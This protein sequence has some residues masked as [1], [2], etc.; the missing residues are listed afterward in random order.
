[1]KF[2]IQKN[3]IVTILAKIQGLAGRR[4]SLAIT[5]CIC[6]TVS[7]S[8]LQII[9]TDLE[10]GY[11]GYFPVE[12]EISGT[13]AISA[14]KF[15]EIIREFPDSKIL[16]EESE[17]RRVDIGNQNVQFHIKGM[18]PED[19]PT[20]PT[21]E[22]VDYFTVDASSFKKMIDKT[23]AVSGIGE[24]KKPHINGVFF[25]RLIDRNPAVI[26]MVSTDGSRLSKYDFQFP[27]DVSITK[28][29]GVL[30]PK[31]GLNEVSKFLPDS[32]TVQVGVHE[33]YFVVASS[34]ETIYIR[35]L[36]GQFPQ[37]EDIIVRD[38][39]LMI[40]V[41]KERFHHMVKRMSILCNDSYRAA[42]FTFDADKLVINATNPDIGESKEDMPINYKGGKIQVAFN[43]KFFIDTVNS[44]D[45]K[46]I[47]IN[48][49]SEERPCLI[50]G[51]EDKSYLSA[52]MPMR[53]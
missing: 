33:S 43:P 9:A 5:E 20:T 42:L 7:D 2:T 41:E 35:L 34:R 53:V 1:M 18:N 6:I 25:E 37:Y 8:G 14:R 38:D 19:F 28:G 47:V 51:K 4:S 48:I 11:K 21:I 12:H 49:K 27:E 15:Y 10:T 17:N 50:E 26:R 22:D 44:I 30:I 32:G 23:I 13:M 24:D 45:E 39:G 52:I 3:E 46:E 31:K 40:S 29:P 16:V 36:E